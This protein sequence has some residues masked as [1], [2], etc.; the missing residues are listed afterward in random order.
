[1]FLCTGSFSFTTCCYL[2]KLFSFTVQRKHFLMRYI[3]SL[4]LIFF[5]AFQSISQEKHFILIQSETKQLFNVTINGKVYSANSSGYAIIPKLQNGEYTMVLAFPENTFPDQAFKFVIDQ[6]DLGFNLQNMGEKGWVLSNLQTQSL[7]MAEKEVPQQTAVSKSITNVGDEPITFNKA[8]NNVAA[9]KMIDKP[10]KEKEPEAK[11]AEVITAAVDNSSIVTS[12][13]APSKIEIKDTSII[14]KPVSDNITANIQTKDTAIV[15]LP[16]PFIPPIIEAID[17]AIAN[18]T[19]IVTQPIL[20]SETALPSTKEPKIKKLVEN[21]NEDGITMS[22]SDSNDKKADTIDVYIKSAAQPNVEI[23]DTVQKTVTDSNVAAKIEQLNNR[24]DDVKF[25]EIDMDKKSKEDSKNTIVDS[26]VAVVKRDT[27]ETDKVIE[28]EPD[29]TIIKDTAKVAVETV[30][31]VANNKPV[32]E[33][34]SAN[35][36]MG[37]ASEIDYIKLRRKMALEDSDDRMIREARKV[38]K[39]ICFTTNQM[40]GLSTLFLS[41]EGRYHFFSA[42]YSF[43]SDPEQ[44]STLQSEFIDPY[45]INRFKSIIHR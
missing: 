15:I 19:P 3:L 30:E 31:A 39:Q 22:F 29:K 13:I 14:T 25:I 28:S 5:Y 36:C 2:F 24:K 10:I 45:F 7:T 44:Y 9:V 42:A 1:M 16:D 35:L 20:S 21:R 4:S 17:T 11:V 41:D 26:S 33:K 34:K 18:P 40:K 6:K 37:I 38:F 12:A 43:V 32:A 27:K 23:R 8:K